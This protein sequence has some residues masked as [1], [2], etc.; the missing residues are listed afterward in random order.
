M[1]CTG[2]GR[3][4]RDRLS[5]D[6]LAEGREA[7]PS[8]APSS[9]IAAIWE[10]AGAHEP[11]RG[12]GRLPAPRSSSSEGW[13]LL[14][15]SNRAVVVC[16]LF[17]VSGRLCGRCHVA[18][19]CARGGPPFPPPFL[20]GVVSLGAPMLRAGVPVPCASP[21]LRAGVPTLRAGV[22]VVPLAGRRGSSCVRAVRVFWPGCPPFLVRGFVPLPPRPVPPLW[23][24]LPPS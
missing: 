22:A 2:L 20:R 15:V 10:S 18:C 7:G 13:L 23:P 3:R 1:P 14:V 24:P 4:H 21:V 5:Q 8:L 12:K 11:E 17:V 16:C 6:S 19:A 9:A